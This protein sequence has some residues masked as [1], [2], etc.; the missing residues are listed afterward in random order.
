MNQTI[1]S[2]SES[3]IRLYKSHTR[4]SQDQKRSTKTRLYPVV[5]PCMIQN[6]TFSSAIFCLPPKPVKIKTHHSNSS[7]RASVGTIHPLFFPFAPN[8]GKTGTPRLWL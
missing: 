2:V 6:E 4:P 7:T 5:G 1:Q 8:A 3:R